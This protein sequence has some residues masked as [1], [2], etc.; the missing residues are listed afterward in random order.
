MNKA[1]FR[2]P[3]HYLLAAL[4]LIM[5]GCARS[6]NTDSTPQPSTCRLAN[7]TSSLTLFGNTSATNENLTF[8]SNGY[9]TAIQGQIA[10]Q[11]VNVTYN[12]GLNNVLS[13][14]ASSGTA[15]RQPVYN[16]TNTLI[17]RLNAAGG[18]FEQLTYDA[19]N[20]LVGVRAFNS[21]GVA[22]TRRSFTYV[23]TTNNIAADSNFTINTLTGA[24]VI[25]QVTLY[26]GYDTRNGPL[27]AFG[28]LPYLGNLDPT[29]LPIGCAPTT[30][31]NPTTISVVI[32]ATPPATGFITVNGNLTNQYNVSSYLTSASGQLTLVGAPGNVGNFSATLTYTGCQ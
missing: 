12:Y 31:N 5:A 19:A 26:G 25:V 14:I 13:T 32:P 16:G 27:R 18:A 30:D 7:I 24:S 3:L 22:T 11:T 4:V 8:N 9:L 2:L 1:N 28:T 17:T 10:G 15:I 29:S 23:G 6:S 20:R 21:N